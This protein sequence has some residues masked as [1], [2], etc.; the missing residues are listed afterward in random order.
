MRIHIAGL[1]LAA[2]AHSV[3]GAVRRGK[4]GRLSRGRETA[5]SVILNSR[6][7]ILHLQAPEHLPPN[8]TTTIT[9]PAEVATGFFAVSITTQDTTS[10]SYSSSYSSFYSSFYSSSSFTINELGSSLSVSTSALAV[11]NKIAATSDIAHDIPHDTSSSTLRT[12]S[13]PPTSDHE[14]TTLGSPATNSQST[15]IPS[16]PNPTASAEQAGNLEISAN[17][18]RRPPS[19]PNPAT[20]PAHNTTSDPGSTTTPLHHDSVSSITSSWNVTQ[21]QSLSAETTSWPQSATCTMLRGDD[22]VTVFSIIFTAT[23]TIYGNQSYTP[24]YPTIETPNYCG[25]GSSLPPAISLSEAPFISSAPTTSETGGSVASTQQPAASCSEDDILSEC[26]KS[27]THY[28]SKETDQ[29]KHGGSTFSSSRVTVTFV[30]TDKNPATVFTSEPVPRFRQSGMAGSITAQRKSSQGS[31]GAKHGPQSQQDSQSQGESQSRGK[32][33]SQGSSR[34]QDNTR[35][36]DNTRTQDSPRTKDN[37]RTQDNPQTQNNAITLDSPQSTEQKPQ[38]TFTVTARGG[39]VIINDQTFSSL[40]PDQTTTVTVG[41]GTFTINPTEVIGE[42][43]TVKKPQPVGTAVTVLTP[44]TGSAGGLFVTVSGSE[45][46]VDGTKMEI[47]PLATTT[48]VNGETVSVGPG[49]VVVD[50]ETVKFRAVGGHQTDVV[51]TG[52]EMVTAIGQSIYVFHSTTLTYGPGIPGTSEVV[53]DDTITIGPSG[54]TVD[55]TTMGGT[56]AEPTDTTYEIVG[57]ATITKLSPS[58]V[59]IDGTTFTVGPK[60][61][62][63]TK[64]IGGET[65]TIRSDGVVISTMTLSYP[66][67][68]STV[69]TIKATATRT[70]TQTAATGRSRGGNGDNEDNAGYLLKPSLTAAMAGLCIAIGVWGGL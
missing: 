36:Q 7:E 1:L 69:T 3:A 29:P 40:K 15:I 31:G 10:S 65:I 53:D 8:A 61:T 34:D 57:G 24:P 70:S 33:Q 6:Q 2:A 67:G 19:T 16:D 17:G 52:G 62:K 28:S 66:F 51:V 27:S 39:Q 26:L 59:V 23:I 55:G 54:I 60:A 4:F 5:E 50:N 56:S 68:S 47:P 14:L 64:T 58:F 22:P 11:P 43:A 21:S 32:F 20:T 30:T 48:M 37:P 41:Q 44:T 63:T 18:E 12:Q 25:T 35:S 42:G 45:A 49:K 38:T 13:N 9:T 46:V